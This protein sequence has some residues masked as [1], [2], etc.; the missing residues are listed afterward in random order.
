MLDKEYNIP[1]IVS[2]VVNILYSFLN[3]KVSLLVGIGNNILSLKYNIY[4]GNIVISTLWG[5]N[6]KIFQYNFSK[7]I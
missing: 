1:F 2:L 3:I 4:L 7:T 6:G 5:G